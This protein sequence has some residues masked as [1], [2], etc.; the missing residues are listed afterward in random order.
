VRRAA[1]KAEVGLLAR[2]SCSEGRGPGRTPRW[3]AER[4]ACV[5]RSKRN[6]RAAPHPRGSL[7]PKG[8]T[9]TRRCACRRSAHP[10]IGWVKLKLTR[11]HP[12][13][14]TRRRGL[15]DIV[16]WD[17]TA[18]VRRRAASSAALIHPHAQERACAS[19]PK[20]WNV[21]ARVSKGQDE[22]LR[23]PSC[24]ETHRGAVQLWNDLRSCRAT[25]LL[26]MRA[27]PRAEH[28]PAAVR[29]HR[30]RG[31]I[32]SGL[33]FTMNFATAACRPRRAFIS[34]HAAPDRAATRPRA[35]ELPPS[36]APARC[37]PCRECG[38]RSPQR[39]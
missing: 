9:K 17:D 14:G 29:N 33:L 19:V 7:A 36:C 18:A 25:M 1:A 5:S 15:F 31:F 21:R 20:K 24:F 32:V 16:R 13:A 35:V 38:I 6:V 22:Q 11:A 28:Q 8:A 4:R 10:S 27:R 37:D 3:S 39:R 2:R 30:R 12:R 26:G 34:L 23:S